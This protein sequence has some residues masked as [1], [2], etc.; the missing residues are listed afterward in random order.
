MKINNAAAL[1]LKFIILAIAVAC[2]RSSLK[3]KI[4]DVVQKE[5]VPGPK[6]PS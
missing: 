4:N 6:K 2:N 3:K 1:L 5:P